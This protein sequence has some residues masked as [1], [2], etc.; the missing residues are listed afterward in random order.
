MVAVAAAHSQRATVRQTAAEERGQRHEEHRRES[1]DKY[2]VKIN[3][4]CDVLDEIVETLRDGQPLTGDPAPRYVIFKVMSELEASYFA[5]VYPKGQ[6][7]VR[8]AAAAVHDALLRAREVIDPLLTH[9]EDAQDEQSRKMQQYAQQ[10]LQ[11][12]NARMLYAICISEAI[13]AG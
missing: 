6:E 1:Y 5:D 13:Y 7:H 3:A 12:R 10:R 11:V 2:A 4:A 9:P 8:N